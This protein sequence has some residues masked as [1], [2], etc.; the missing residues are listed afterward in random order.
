[1]VRVYTPAL[2]SYNHSRYVLTFCFFPSAF[3]VAVMCTAP[4]ERGRYNAHNYNPLPVVLTR[5]SGVFVWDVEGK[6]YYDWLSAYSA[7][8]QVCW[9]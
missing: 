4:N 8:N 2:D 7:V 1:M 6:Q 9:Q 3:P 5:G